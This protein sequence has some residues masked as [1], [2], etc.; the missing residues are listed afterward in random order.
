MKFSKSIPS[1]DGYE[2]PLVRQITAYLAGF[3]YIA[4]M[5]LVYCHKKMIPNE[6]RNE[7]NKEKNTRFSIL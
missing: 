3:A 7:V 1:P 5:N 4:N 6:V 2:K